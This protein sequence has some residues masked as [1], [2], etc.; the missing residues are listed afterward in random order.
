MAN[1]VFLH[2]ATPKSGTTY[3]QRVLWRNA[4]V[5]RKGNVLLPGTFKRHYTAAKSVTDRKQMRQVNIKVTGAWP[6]LAEQINSWPDDALV[7]HELFAPA[8]VE[9]AETAKAA[10][11]AAET[12]LILT[13][14]ALHKQL[15]AAWQQGVR[16]GNT[17]TF[18]RYLDRIRTG[19]GTAAKWFWSVQSLADIAQRWGV[20]I[21]AEHI[22]IVTV[23][24]DSSNPG[25][26]W[27]R[28]ASVLSIDPASCDIDIPKKNVSVGAVEAE[29]MRRVHN[30]GDSRFRDDRRYSPWTRR[31]L[32]KGVL[33]ERRGTPF[34][35]PD[36]AREWLSERTA[37]MTRA[38]EAGGFSVVGDLRELDWQ[39]PLVETRQISD[40]TEEEIA[41]LCAWT[42]GRLQEEL[43][44][45]H[46]AAALPAVG[47]DDG[48]DGILELLEHIRAAE[49]GVPPRRA[50]HVPRATRATSTTE[51][52][53][54]A[55][56]VARIL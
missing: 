38:I 47:P 11:N 12:H 18:D 45:R 50:P 44:Q 1:R 32:V 46:P 20:G 28:Y 33:S 10:L 24:P 3:L 54:R 31:L 55:V 30:R 53:R 51:R 34:G 19:E 43:V 22:H 2:V 36:D 37:A 39:P 56:S 21:P 48:I 9:Q 52:L 29:L 26:L 6:R 41:E 8:T 4:E 23:P 49:E 40:V 13:A 25:L 14:R 16:G 7:S 42:I 17:L 27:Q 15:P 35:P 5:L